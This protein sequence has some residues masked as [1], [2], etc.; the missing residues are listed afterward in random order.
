[1][2]DKRII[3]FLYS[4]ELILERISTVKYASKS[5]GSNLPLTP[6]PIRRVIKVSQQGA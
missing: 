6:S 2:P 3:K 5:S 4:K 1:M